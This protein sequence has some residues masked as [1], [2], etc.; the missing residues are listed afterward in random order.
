ILLMDAEYEITEL[1]EEVIPAASVDPAQP[2]TPFVAKHTSEP[3]VPAT[4]TAEQLDEAEVQLREALHRAG[5]DTREVG[6]IDRRNGELHLR[7]WAPTTDRKNEILSAINTVPYLTPE[8]YDAETA[9]SD[10]PP[11]APLRQ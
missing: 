7:L 1:L 4:P 5:A 3:A 8:I 2:E 6:E 9:T 11:V 10:L